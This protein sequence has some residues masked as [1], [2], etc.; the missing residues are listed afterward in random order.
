M[1]GISPST[2]DKGIWD[3]AVLWL[4]QPSKLDLSHAYLL[5]GPER[6]NV[7]ENAGKDFM[8]SSE[9]D[10]YHFCSYSFG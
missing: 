3:P 1:V 4:H 8:G 10:I 2:A 5:Q 6:E 7:E 9:S